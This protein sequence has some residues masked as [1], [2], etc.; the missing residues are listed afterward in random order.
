MAAADPLTSRH[1]EE[2]TKA[3]YGTVADSYAE[4][5][6]GSLAA[7]PAD[8]AVLGLFAESILARG[9]GLVADVGCGPG[10]ITAYLH[11]LGLDVIGLDLTRAMVELGHRQYPALSFIEASIAALP[12]RAGSVAGVVAWYSMIHTPPQDRPGVF[13]EL[14]KVLQPGGLFL[15]AFHIGD[16][17]V[18]LPEAYG[19]AIA[20]DTYRLPPAAVAAHVQD[21]GLV[22]TGSFER[23]P[24]GREPAWQ[25]YL[26]AQKRDASPADDR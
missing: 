21:A 17:C 10:R 15:T 23:E 22:V 8:R 25:G 12:I 3:A 26:L 20:L 16:E 14:A 6:E 24:I 2:R 4:L 7:S 1:H 18:H 13:A 9:G 11:D 5:L 19:H